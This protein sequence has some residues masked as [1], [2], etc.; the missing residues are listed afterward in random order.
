MTKM[1]EIAKEKDNG[2]FA[3]IGMQKTL[4]DIW[5]V[6][7]NSECVEY[8]V[9]TFLECVDSMDFMSY[10]KTVQVYR[11]EDFIDLA[12]FGSLDNITDALMN[13]YGIE[14]FY[15]ITSNL[16]YTTEKEYTD[17]M[18]NRKKLN[19]IGILIETE[20]LAVLY[21]NNIVTQKDIDIYLEILDNYGFDIEETYDCRE[22]TVRDTADT[23][24][25][26]MNQIFEL[27]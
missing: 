18:N 24:L 17:K 3:K 27:W 23:I 25:D 21:E 16:V 26:R 5:G 15:D 14:V 4:A 8:T 12:E 19:Y 20:K 2:F 7:T 10:I 1:F 22:L 13:I 6:D 11:K 9:D